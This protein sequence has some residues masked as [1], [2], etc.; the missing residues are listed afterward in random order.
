MTKEPSERREIESE[1]LPARWEAV[2]SDVA[3]GATYAVVDHGRVVALIQAPCA[4]HGGL[5]LASESAAAY[6]GPAPSSAALTD[7]A[8]TRLLGS[9]AVRSTLGVF[10]LGPSARIHQREVARRTGLGLRSAQLALER[11]ERAGLIKSVRDGNR[12]YYSASRTDRFEAVRGLLSPEFGLAAAVERA[13]APAR[14]RIDWAFI[15]GSV[16]RGEDRVD[17]DVDLLIVGSVTD[18]EM[19]PVVAALQREIGHEVDVAIYP[20]ERFIRRRDEGNHF[21]TATL[22]QPRLD[23]IG[24]ADGIA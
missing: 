13:L 20:L 11:L 1:D 6:G 24:S 14:D 15:Y 22:A 2:V 16:A 23:V 9:A 18:D 19:A 8:V 21:I 10:L 12:R 5:L 7:T 17:S 4:D 3:A